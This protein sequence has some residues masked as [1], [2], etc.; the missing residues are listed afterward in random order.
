LDMPRGKIGQAD[1]AGLLQVILVGRRG[2]VG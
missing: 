2:L 1:C